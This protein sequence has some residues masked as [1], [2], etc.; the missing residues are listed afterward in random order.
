MV[1][2]SHQRTI[3]KYRSIALSS[4]LQPLF[5]YSDEETR[6]KSSGVLSLTRHRKTSSRESAT[7]HFISIYDS[8]PV[9]TRNYLDNCVIRQH[10]VNSSRRNSSVS[11]SRLSRNRFARTQNCTILAD[12]YPLTKPKCHAKL[13]LKVSFMLRL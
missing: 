7:P 6:S 8:L 2:R 13:T 9:H 10:V 12:G 3:Q 1:C 4:L 11:T 5:D